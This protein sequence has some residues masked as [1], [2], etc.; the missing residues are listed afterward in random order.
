MSIDRRI[1]E[2]MPKRTTR[3]RSTTQTV[4]AAN[5]GLPVPEVAAAME[6]M[7]RSGHL[8]VDRRGN[9]HREI[10]PRIEN[11][12]ADNGANSHNKA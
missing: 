11:G 10:E 6:R 12:D 4:V 1:W 9:W 5:L 3:A 8:M 7:V 2:W